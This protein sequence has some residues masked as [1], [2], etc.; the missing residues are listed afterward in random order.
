MAIADQVGDEVKAEHEQRFRESEQQ[1]KPYPPNTPEV[2]F[3]VV[4]P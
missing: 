1:I 2:A 3:L 4:L